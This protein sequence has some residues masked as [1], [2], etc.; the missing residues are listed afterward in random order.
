VVATPNVTTSSSAAPKSVSFSGDTLNKQGTRLTRTSA[1]AQ[2]ADS[3]D[4]S[5]VHETRSDDGSTSMSVEETRPNRSVQSRLE[6]L[7]QKQ[8]LLEESKALDES[9]EMYAYGVQR[10]GVFFRRSISQCKI[11]ANFFFFMFIRRSFRGNAL[12]ACA[13][14]LLLF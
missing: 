2:S 9:E 7:A 10:F 8:R 12:V 4:E 3:G 6:Q 11:M 5:S 13:P 1:S 14:L